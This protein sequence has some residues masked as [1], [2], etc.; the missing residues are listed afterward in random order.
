MER[1]KDAGLVGDADGRLGDGVRTGSRRDEETGAE[2]CASGAP[3]RDSG[4][5]SAGELNLNLARF[6]VG[7]GMGHSATSAAALP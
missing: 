5:A 6:R 2:L 1:G 4:P 3:S 7:D